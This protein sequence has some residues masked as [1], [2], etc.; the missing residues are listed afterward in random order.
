MIQLNFGESVVCS[1]AVDVPHVTTKVAA[2]SEIMATQVAFERPLARVLAEVI[3]EVA[4]LDEDRVAV[5]VHASIEELRVA[6]ALLR[7]T[8]DLVKLFRY[9]GKGL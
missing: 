1:F 5:L 4:G 9:V 3:P 6:C 8:N 7:V 2:L